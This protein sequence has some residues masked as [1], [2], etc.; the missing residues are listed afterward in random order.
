MNDDPHKLHPSVEAFCKAQEEA[1]FGLKT[2]GVFQTIIGPCTYADASN[3]TL[4]LFY[5]QAADVSFIMKSEALARDLADA[6]NRVLM[7]HA[8]EDA[9]LEK[10]RLQ[11]DRRVNEWAAQQR[12]DRDKPVHERVRDIV[13]DSEMPF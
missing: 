2:P 1:R 7:R 8:A 10:S 6:I 4:R 9:V 11:E 5:G 13:V 12:A 3:R